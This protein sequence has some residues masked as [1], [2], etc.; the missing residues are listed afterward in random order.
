MTLITLMY[1]IIFVA[2]FLAAAWEAK[3]IFGM[4]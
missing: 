3:V 1:R 2:A 4:R